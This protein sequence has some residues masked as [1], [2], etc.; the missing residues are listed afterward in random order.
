M[1]HKKKLMGILK[2]RQQSFKNILR[3]YYPW[4]SK[5][6][7]NLMYDIVASQELQKDRRN[8]VKN[9]QKSYKAQLLYLFGQIDSDSNGVIDL[10]EFKKVIKLN[11][12]FDDETAEKLF[13]KADKDKNG[14]LDFQEFT[15]LLSHNKYLRENL[16]VI[17]NQATKQKKDEHKKRLSV[18]FKNLPN[19]P[20]KENWRP[21]LANLQS[22]SHIKACLA[23][24]LLFDEYYNI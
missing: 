15:E 10:I 19:S 3:S 5:R 20:L 11:G 12:N 2:E 22:P 13:N 4:V 7:L 14:L 16:S 1:L 17:L 6:E 23:D 21:S 9:I 24:K 18:I 8:W